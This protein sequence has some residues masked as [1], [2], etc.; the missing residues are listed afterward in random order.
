[1]PMQRLRKKV[2]LPSIN[3][4]AKY[5]I[6]QSFLLSLVPLLCGIVL[7]LLLFVFAKLN[8]YYLEANGLILDGQIRDAYYLDVATE[9]LGVLGYLALQMLVTSLVAFVV[10]RWATAPFAAA[11]RLVE[12]ALNSAEGPR[13]FSRWLSESPRFDRVV[14]GFCQRLRQGG[15]KVELKTLPFFPLSFRFLV[16]FV[17]V[18]AGLSWATGYVMGIIFGSI[19]RH[20]VDLA[21]R[22]VQNSPS[23]PHYFL[24]QE[25]IL[26]EA[27]LLLAGLSF[28]T[29]VVIGFRI[30]RYMGNMI[31]VFS[32][33]IREDK[34]PISLRSD[35]VYQDLAALMNEA[36]EKIS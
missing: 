12:L 17:I 5:R 18:A 15:E 13:P 22:L 36:R 21:L 31:F 16:K 35:D 32:R 29:F 1:M 14:W 20:I 24:A 10:M 30:A 23:L 9:F 34:F 25:E 8:L 3:P 6:R 2:P 4:Q 11:Y 28:L 26:A 33:A 19:Y 27:T 7:S